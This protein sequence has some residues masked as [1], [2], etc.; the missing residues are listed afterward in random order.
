MTLHRGVCRAALPHVPVCPWV[1][2]VPRWRRYR[3]ACDC[4]GVREL[5]RVFLRAVF[6][7]RGC[8]AATLLAITVLVEAP[9]PLR[10]EQGNLRTGNLLKP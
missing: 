10:G 8:G 5:R 3:M 6:A 2:I 4:R 1:P 7:C 9:R